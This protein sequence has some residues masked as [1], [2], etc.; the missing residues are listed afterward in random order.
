MIFHFA[1][2][3]GAVSPPDEPHRFHAVQEG[4]E[5]SDS[6]ELKQQLLSVISEGNQV[7]INQEITQRNKSNRMLP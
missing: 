6:D 1:I 4:K 7:K 3:S 5:V 2:N